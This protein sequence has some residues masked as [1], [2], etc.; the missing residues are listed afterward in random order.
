MKLFEAFVEIK[1]KLAPLKKSLNM[2]KAAV[3]SAIGAMNRMFATMMNIGKKAFLGIA[4]AMSVA[5]WKAIKQ[6]KAIFSLTATLKVSGEEVTQN[7]HRF[8]EFAAEVQRTTKFGDEDTLM[9]MS[10]MKSLGVTADALEGAT[11]KAIGLATAT[12]RDVQSMAM[13]IALAEQGEFTM[14][15]RYIPALRS[16]T[17]ATKQL[18][19][20]NEF[21][22]KGF[23]LAQEEAKT[24][25]TALIQMKNAL[26]DVM[27]VIGAPMLKGIA[28][29]ARAIT[30]WAKDNESAIGIWAEKAAATVS[31][32]KDLMMSFVKW[33]REDW[34]TNT[35]IA[36]EA[37]LPLWEALG[38]S[39]VLI[40]K[41]AGE[42]AYDAFTKTFG[43]KFGQW[44]VDLGMPEGPL[45]K[46]SVAMPAVG[47]ARLG[48]M[49]AGVG[50]ME[51]SMAPS[52]SASWT[53]IGKQIAADFDAAASKAFL[54]LPDKLQAAFEKDT[55]RWRAALKIIAERSASAALDET[56]AASGGGYVRGSG[57][58]RAL[59][60]AGS[61]KKKIGFAGITDVWR[62]ISQSLTEGRSNPMLRTQ[63]SML[64]FMRRQFE[65]QV[66]IHK[67]TR[68]T[69]SE[70]KGVGKVGR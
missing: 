40:L 30:K 31:Y 68:K 60:A 33:L 28:K 57:I 32:V 13:Y 21:G 16:T 51:G 43:M 8:R 4:A 42:K 3:S 20:I 15:R 52:A 12:G 39:I 46:L 44:L 49:K 37:T 66:A 45:G 58:A 2:A 70:M 38:K 10:L 50:L 7:M 54:L 23:K 64:H 63:E 14:L 18:A 41:S 5:T 6:E 19:I 26:G 47:L 55:A 22:A 25:A 24:T 53:N 48:I 29:S 61:N 59:K 17:D 35:G 34:T 1:G 11:K 27:E 69:A 9:L 65:Q 67:Y 62:T 36:L 56:G